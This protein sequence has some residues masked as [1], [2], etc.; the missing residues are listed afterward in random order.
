MLTSGKSYTANTIVAGINPANGR[1][2]WRYS[3][4]KCL[5]PIPCPTPLGQ[6]RFFLTGGDSKSLIFQ[7]LHQGKRW[8]C[9][10]MVSNIS[11]ASALQNALLYQEHLYVNSA[12]NGRGLCCL[13][14]HG[15][16]VWTHNT[17]PP[18]EQGGNLIIADGMLYFTHGKNG[19][20]YLAAANPMRYSE[21]AAMQALAPNQNWAPMALAEGKLL[22]RDK[23]HLH[24]FDVRAR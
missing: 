10:T 14:L 4:W 3:G 17:T 2:L 6:G 7:V 20:L 5:I 15:Q 22:V 19:M 1:V 13:D 24:C 18:L 11:C 9:R 12:S 23:G 8:R 21:L 16:I